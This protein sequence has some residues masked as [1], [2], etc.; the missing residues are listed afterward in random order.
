MREFSI[1]VALAF[2]LSGCGDECSSYSNYTC[3]QI[4]DATYDVYFYFPDDREQPLGRVTG[5]QSCSSTAGAYAS[6]TGA[7]KSWICCM[8]TSKSSCEEKHR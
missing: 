8:V 2:F 1:S 7:P 3:Q 4:E 6:Q 5:L